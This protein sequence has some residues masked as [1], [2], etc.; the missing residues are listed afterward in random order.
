[1]QERTDCHP[2]LKSLFLSKAHSGFSAFLSST[3]FTAE[4]MD[5]SSSIPRLPEAVGVRRLLRQGHRFIIP[6]QPLVRIP[7]QPQ[8]PSGKAATHHTSVLPMP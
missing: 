1:M 8:R 3:H 7:Q 6:R 5:N 2:G 4:L